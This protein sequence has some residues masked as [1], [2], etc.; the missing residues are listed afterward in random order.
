MRLLNN[1]SLKKYNSFGIETIARNFTII[2]SKDDLIETVQQFHDQILQSHLVLGSGSNIL[3]TK[4]LLDS[5]VLKNEIKGIQ[6]IR[7]DELYF[8]VDVAA[9][10]NWHQFVLYCIQQGWTGVENLSLIPGT[11][12]ASPIQNIGAYG[13]E[14]KD[15]IES[16][17]A[18]HI[19]DQSMQV[20]TNTD[21]SFDY[22]NSVFKSRWK[23]QFVITKVL[24]RFSKVPIFK[25]SYGA[26]EIALNDM[27]VKEPSI[28]S[29]SDAIIKIRS[30]KLPDPT[31]IGNA[32]SFFK[33]PSITFEHFEKIKT[34]Y[35]ELTGYK[36]KDGSIK[37]AA[38]WLIEKAGWKGYREGDAGC[39][40]LQALVLI[41]YG[42]ATG[43]EIFA[44]SEK[45]IDSILQ[46]FNIVLEREVNIL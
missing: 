30:S 42:N 9:G 36:N 46:D 31:I 20:F 21:C 15:L 12:G 10:E 43:S 4:P 11:V 34:I 40:S 27:G 6:L 28:Q 41:N 5:F 16:V 13:V 37:I 26:I 29:V 35:P 1:I 8:Y 7:E 3:F 25:T 2:Q 23:N 45:I 38:G 24:F 14:V 32:G 44:L 33:N 18:Y 39:H 19:A 17:E 22:R